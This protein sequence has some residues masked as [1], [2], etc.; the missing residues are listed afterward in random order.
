MVEQDD[1]IVWE[2]EVGG[3]VGR[4][5]GGGGGCTGTTPPRR[6]STRLDQG[7]VYP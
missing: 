6:W 1:C 3:E 7:F 4:W 5:G 2:Y